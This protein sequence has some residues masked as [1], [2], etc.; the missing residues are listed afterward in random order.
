MSGTHIESFGQYFKITDGN[1]VAYLP[2]KNTIIQK[3]NE[4]TLFL[5]NGDYIKYFKASQLPTIGGD[6]P[7]PDINII[8]ETLQTQANNYANPTTEIDLKNADMIYQLDMLYDDRSKLIK[9]GSG[10][11]TYKSNNNEIVVTDSSCRSKEFIHVPFGNTIVAMITVKNYNDSSGA[12]V[13]TNEV[14]LFDD[15]NGIFVQFEYNDTATKSIKIVKRSID[16]DGVSVS[17][18]GVSPSNWNI[19]QFDGN[20]ISKLNVDSVDLYE[21]FRTWVFIID[22]LNGSKIQIGIL[23][24]GNI[25]LMHSFDSFEFAQSLPLQV[26][27]G[28]TIHLKN[29][30]VY[31]MN[32]YSVIPKTFSQTTS[33]NHKVNLDEQGNSAVVC[34][35]KLNPAYYKSKIRIK[36]IHIMDIDE[37]NPSSMCEWMLVKSPTTN[38]KE[39]DEV[40]DT[41]TFTKISLDNIMN[42]IDVGFSKFYQGKNPDFS[43]TT[44]QTIYSKDGTILASGYFQGPS[45]NDITLHNI[46]LLLHNSTTPVVDTDELYLQVTCHKGSTK[47]LLAGITWEEF[48]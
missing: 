28:N 48:L 8:V 31:S 26:I 20:G 46:D 25:H 24:D 33:I 17:E 37:T 45:T 14:G 11:V 27:S 36:K 16:S 38:I 3:N 10:E 35:L 19:D 5:K 18:D 29:M 13:Y 32:K 9:N 12:S 23:H 15:N 43:F 30:V 22:N 34:A 6:G 1:V 4:S 44:N 7:T 42:G 47:E 2:K 21:E 39:E 41:V 40:L